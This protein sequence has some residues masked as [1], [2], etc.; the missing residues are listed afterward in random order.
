M[1]KKERRRKKKKKVKECCSGSWKVLRLRSLSMLVSNQEEKKK[2]KV[3]VLIYNGNLDVLLL[4]KT[5]LIGK[6]EQLRYYE[7]NKSE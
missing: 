5:K 1:P 6:E 3:E 7:G 4:C 2:R